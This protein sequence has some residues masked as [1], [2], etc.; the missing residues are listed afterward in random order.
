MRNKD[1]ITKVTLVIL[2]SDKT[3]SDMI[4]YKIK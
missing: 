1:N 4:N 2:K 3:M